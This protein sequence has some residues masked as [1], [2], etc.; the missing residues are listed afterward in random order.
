MLFKD[1]LK[2]ETMSKLK[3][4]CEELLWVNMK[5]KPD[6]LLGVMYRAE[7]TDILTES[8]GSTIFEKNIE[9]ATELSKNILLIGDLNCDVAADC[10]DKPTETLKEICQTHGLEQ[11]IDK[12]TRINTKTR[13][14]TTIDHLWTD[15]K[16]DIK[17]TGTFI[18]L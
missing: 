16:A 13:K 14:A 10:G 8:E 3:N 15:I 11:I 18:G 12:P 5:G 4:E 7:Y 6:I 1:N 2:V 9:K 17:E